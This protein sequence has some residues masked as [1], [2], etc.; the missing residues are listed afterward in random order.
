MENWKMALKGI[1]VLWY[2]RCKSNVVVRRVAF[3]LFYSFPN[4]IFLY[5]SRQGHF[6]ML[7]CCNFVQ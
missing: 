6:A 5:I 3:L 4:H 2:A 1:R 7:L